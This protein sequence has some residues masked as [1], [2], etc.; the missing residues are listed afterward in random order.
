MRHMMIFDL[1]EGVA[2]AGSIRKAAAVHNLTA[3]ALNRRIQAFEAEVGAPLFER[4][5]SG[6]R[7]NAAGELFLRHGRAQRADLQRVIGTIGE[8]STVRRGHVSLAASQALMPSFLPLQIARFRQ[9]NPGITFTVN[10]RDRLAAERELKEFECDLALVLEPVLMAEFEIIAS[11]T[12][13][14]AAVMA[15]TH[16]LASVERLR[17]RH[18][19]DVDHVIPGE[20]FGV[21]ALLERALRNSSRRLDPVL[22]SDSFEFLR[23]YVRRAD[24]VGFEIAIALAEEE[25]LL[26]RPLPAEDVPLG[27]LLLGQ[28]RGRTLPAA[29]AKF[30]E[31]LTR[32]LKP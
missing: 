16:P 20:R 19:L 24:A 31:H 28:Q 11:V 3:S 2:K 14:V 1:I 25:G 12:Q 32:A 23:R 15:P 26:A 18:C 4:L 7:L 13:P 8:L 6:M 22:V 21:R 5:P 9:D 10:E 30:A 27:H 17:L 29:A